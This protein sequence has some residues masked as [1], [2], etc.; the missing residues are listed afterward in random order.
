MQ[1]RRYVPLL[2]LLYST[3]LAAQSTFVPTALSL[4]DLSAF[5]DPG[6][7]WKIVGHAQVEADRS[8][9][10]KTEKGSGVLVNRPTEKQGSNLTTQLEHGDLDLWVE[11]MMAPGSNSGIYLQG[12]YEVQLLDSWGKPGVGY[13]DMGG[14]YER[15]DDARSEGRRGYAGHAP[16]VNVARAPGLWQTLHVRFRAPRFDAAGK[17][18]ADAR[19]LEIRLNGVVIHENLTLSGPTRGA[20]RPGEAARGPLVLQGDHGAVAFRKMR[21]RNYAG[22]P[23]RLEKLGYKTYKGDFGGLP[24]FAEL[25]PEERGET[26]L[27]S[28]QVAKS[29]NEFAVLFEG[30]LDVPEAGRY[31]F[32]LQSNGPAEVHLDGQPLLQSNYSPMRKSIS[33]K[34]GTVPV[35]VAYAKREGWRQGLLGLTVAGENFRNTPLHTANSAIV[36]KPVAPIYVDARGEAEP[37]RSFVDYQPDLAVEKVRIIYALNVG[38]PEGVHY[39]Y[40]LDNGNVPLVWRGDY[41]DATPMWNNRGD[42]NAVPRGSVL[43][44]GLAPPLQ[45]LD[46]PDSP[47]ADSLE[48]ALAVQHQG[49]VLDGDGHPTITYTA[50]GATVHDQ[51]RPVEKGKGFHRQLRID[52]SLPANAYYRVAAGSRI[53]PLENSAYAIDDQRYRIRLG[54]NVKPL[55][56][57]TGEGQELLVPLAGVGEW[58]YVL[59]F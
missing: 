30:S 46:T 21:Y 11:V 1:M 16:R 37:L 7:N 10:F 34:R 5:V 58:S 4:A 39:T 41:L 45:R 32:E 40:D 6:P 14:I 54:D 48:A 43:H 53:D 52:G 24:N 59:E 42:G 33:L 47:W 35:R 2:A 38:H 15:W 18:T 36:A 22:E 56:R 50:F 57:T 27:I 12:R 51:L 3:A 44:L 8:Q 26:D 20:H 17:K 23:V 25:T 9:E 19:I 28:W 29:P 55:L 31:E 13:A 49:Y